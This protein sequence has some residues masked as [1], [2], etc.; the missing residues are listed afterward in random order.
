MNDIE[1]LRAMFGEKRAPTE[2]EQHAWRRFERLVCH[3]FQGVRVSNPLTIA[4]AV[5]EW[6]EAQRI[7]CGHLQVRRGKDAPRRYGTWRTYVCASCSSFYCTDHHDQRAPG[8]LGRWRPPSEYE[9]ATT[10]E[11]ELNDAPQ[12]DTVPRAEHD[13]CLAK[14]LG[15]RKSEGHSYRRR[16]A[17]QKI[18]LRALNRAYTWQSK[19][20]TEYHEKHRAVNEALGIEASVAN[21]DQVAAIRELQSRTAST[22]KEFIKKLENITNAWWRESE[23]AGA[24][25]QALQRCSFQLRGLIMDEITKPS[26]REALTEQAAMERL[27]NLA[28]RESGANI[29]AAVKI[30][31]TQP[32]LVAALSWMAVWESERVVRQAIR[33]TID[34]TREADGKRWDTCF[35]FAFNRLI[36]KWP[37]HTV[38]GDAG[39]DALA[40]LKDLQLYDSRGAE[41]GVLA[42]DVALVA[43]ALRAAT[44]ADTSRAEHEARLRD[45]RQ[46]ALG[47]RV[48]VDYDSGALCE[49]KG[50]WAKFLI[51]R[52]RAETAET[53]LTALQAEHLTRLRKK[54]VDITGA[55]P[56]QILDHDESQLYAL[57]ELEVNSEW[58]RAELAEKRLSEQ[59]A[60]HEAYIINVLGEIVSAQV[61]YDHAVANRDRHKAEYNVRHDQ[62]CD[63]SRKLAA[64]NA[65]WRKLEMAIERL[66]QGPWVL[67]NLNTGEKFMDMGANVI[68]WLAGLAESPYP[69][70]QA[71]TEQPEMAPPETLEEAW[72]DAYKVGY[73]DGTCDAKQLVRRIGDKNPHRKS[74]KAST[75]QA[76]PSPAVGATR[77]CPEC[78]PGCRF[79]EDGCCGTCGRDTVLVPAHP[80]PS[81]AVV[82]VICDGCGTHVS[83]CGPVLWAQQKKCCPDCTHVAQPA[84]GGTERCPGCNSNQRIWRGNLAEGVG[85]VVCGDAWHDPT[86]AEPRGIP[87]TEAL[88][89]YHTERIARGWLADAANALLNALMNG[90]PHERQFAKLRQL[91]DVAI[92]EHACS[93]CPVQPTVQPTPN[94]KRW[95]PKVGDRVRNKTGH[96]NCK[97]EHWGR[98][99]D[100]LTVEPCVVRYD[101]D[102]NRWATDADMLEPENAQWPLPGSIVRLGRTLGTVDAF[103]VRILG[104]H[105]GKCL[106]VLENGNQEFFYPEQLSRPVKRS[107]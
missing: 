87:E 99:G 103:G 36:E 105:K 23:S 91:T 43:S 98:T 93:P 44:K 17:N 107:E 8:N 55:V 49:V 25:A 64:A 37:S 5:G 41:D 77:D 88:A 96:P 95:S 40:L 38:S 18:E 80:A 2:E 90:E 27:N 71:P 104:P 15:L 83:E 48:E 79:D 100:V 3:V 54:V 60:E 62:W 50:L 106:V 28:N 52:L 74:G 13:A 21:S 45:I 84:P 11:D 76:S 66:N 22:S 61:A 82:G 78:G 59:Q 16:I 33:N 31:L 12:P 67:K 32:S 46:A 9:N 20:I 63:V 7:L 101:D 39:R 35:E 102:P 94:E 70:P 53:K 34:D 75:E 42:S 29:D 65:R 68:L 86:P 6:D 81:P 30:A 26:N 14:Q 24:A 47:E 51:E 89:K 1:R 19:S 10:T 4:Q 97:P 73:C 69:A 92:E 56:D 58:E 57:L 85:L 72:D